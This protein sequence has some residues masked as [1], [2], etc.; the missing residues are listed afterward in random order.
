MRSGILSVTAW[1]FWPTFPFTLAGLSLSL[2][3][4]AFSALDPVN[5]SSPNNLEKLFDPRFL[6]MSNPSLFLFNVKLRKSLLI[7]LKN[8]CGLATDT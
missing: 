7:P 5:F 6:A 8:S 1:T 4:P 2:T 3:L